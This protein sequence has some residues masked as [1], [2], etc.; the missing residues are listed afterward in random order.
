MNILIIHLI[1]L[2]ISIH[3]RFPD[4]FRHNLDEY[5]NTYNINKILKIISNLKI[6]NNKPIFIATIM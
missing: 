1:I 6:I 4:I 2:I 5:N 3:I